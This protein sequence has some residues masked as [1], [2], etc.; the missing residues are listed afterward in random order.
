MN[1]TK[2]EKNLLL[3]LFLVILF[4]IYY[5]LVLSPQL[6]KIRELK[7]NLEN[8]QRQKTLVQNEIMSVNNMTREY[9][10][11][12]EKISGMYKRFL[13]EIIQEKIIIILDNMLTNSKLN[14]EKITF[15]EPRITTLDDKE[16]EKREE[17]NEIK[18]LVFDLLG[19]KKEEK[20]GNEEGQE[21]N[22]KS[23]LPKINTMDINISFSGSYENFINFLKEIESC[24][25]E[26]LVSQVNM[27][28]NNTNMLLGNIQLRL[29]SIP[30]IHTQDQ[31]FLTWDIKGDYG[32][33]NPFNSS[34]TVREQLNI[35]NKNDET[36]YH[37]LMSV[38]PTSSDLPTII[39]GKADDNIRSTYVY[40]D[41]PNVED[42]DI[43]F[44]QNNDNYYFKYR[45]KGFTYPEDFNQFEQIELN[46]NEIMVKIL[47][48]YRNSSQDVS[49][50]IVNI[51]NDTDKKVNVRIFNDDTE[52][53]RVYINKKRGHIKV[54]NE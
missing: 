46:N 48:T 29:F 45:T 4:A 42:V 16:E 2:R 7:Q 51:Y 27:V 34:L 13:P 44:Y 38:R 14:A 28:S 11:L 37:F 40:A 8:S 50:A 23:N 25:K 15:A 20:P 24:D 35:S 9:K 31:D 17:I 54:S 5:N 12:N 3:L 1:L 26:I 39:L 41:N 6:E 47:S 19:E 49:G 32:K 52:R 18:S 22:S 36:E 43:Y 21:D 30:K 53:P 10:I 33:A